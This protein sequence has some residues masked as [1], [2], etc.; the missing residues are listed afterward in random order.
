MA[1]S[2]DVSIKV[3]ASHKLSREDIEVLSQIADPD[4]RRGHEQ[5][6]LEKIIDEIVHFAEEPSDLATRAKI[7]AWLLANKK[8]EIRFAFANHVEDA[9]IFHEKIGIF[10]FP[11]GHALAF[12]G[13]AN[14]TI[15]GHERNYE[16]VDVYRT[17]MPGELERVEIKIE[18][19]DEAWNNEAKGL[20]VRRLTSKSVERLEAIAPDVCPSTIHS[21]LEFEDEP[22]QNEDPARWRHQDEAVSKFLEARAGILEMATGT[23]KTRTALKI[24]SHLSEAGDIDSAIVATDGTDLLS[25]WGLELDEWV[26][27]SRSDFIVYKHFGTFHELGNYVLDPK[28]AILVISRQQ[29]DKALERLD[30]TRRASTIIIHDE[31]HGLGVPSLIQSL[32]G[33]HQSFGYRLGLS[34][35]PERAYDAEG[36]KFIEN[37][38]GKTLFDFPLEKAIARGVL[39]EF[40]YTPLD[41]DLT[42]DDRLRL[43]QVYSRQ[44]ARANSSNPMSNEELWTELSKVYKTAEM[45]P[46]V[47]ARFLQSDQSILDSCVIFVE[48]REYGARLLEI[49]HRYTHLYRTYYA[50][51]EQEHLLEF[52]RGQISCLITCHRISQGI[53]IR[54]LKSVILLSSAR[55]KLETI[56]RIGRCLRVDPHNPGKRARVLDFVRPD[57]EEDLFPNADQERAEWLGKISKSR[58]GDHN[59]A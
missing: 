53:D 50:D 55:S 33:Q 45:K 51:D 1:Q 2:N 43:R 11:S 16:S 56:Q 40:D 13:S 54:A 48:T 42:E 32:A 29:L 14:E 7:F 25:Q 9:G 39:C 21:K 24:L 10:N 20:S 8:M 27:K 31:V 22:D 35:T 58:R 3:I 30:P 26:R 15:S 49:L 5:V 47:F 34:A 57:K 6:I 59:A 28:R 38:I 52:A 46:L 18:Q 41:Y 4:Q 19:F 37:E 17:W 44:A 12:T 36:N 23:G